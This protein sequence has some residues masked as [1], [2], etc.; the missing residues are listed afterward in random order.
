MLL[1]LQDA[2]SF[3]LRTVD[4]G[5]LGHLVKRQR[6]AKVQMHVLDLHTQSTH[7][8]IPTDLE[9]L[10]DSTGETLATSLDRAFRRVVDEAVAPAA[11]E[12][13][14]KAVSLYVSCR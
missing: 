6:G 8:E 5:R 2:A 12:T 14:K 1:H 4:A 10:K 9:G 13:H 11:R 3:R 7:F